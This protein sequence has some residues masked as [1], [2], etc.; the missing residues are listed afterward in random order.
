LDS[1]FGK[2]TIQKESDSVGGGGG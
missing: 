2:L 1:I